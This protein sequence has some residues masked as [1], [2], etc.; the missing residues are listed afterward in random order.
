MSR[1]Q[2]K[3]RAAESK[4]EIAERHHNEWQEFR[5][6]LLDRILRDCDTELAKHAKAVA[7]VIK[8]CQEGERNSLG[9]GDGQATQEGLTIRWE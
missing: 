8:A 2:T 1:I 6:I 3:S 5:R 9:Y 7:D 4:A